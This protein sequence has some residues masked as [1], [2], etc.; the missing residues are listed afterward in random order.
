MKKKNIVKIASLAAIILL[1][2]VGA[3]FA[4]F[5]DSQSASNILSMGHVDISLTEEMKDP[6]DPDGPPVP[7]QDPTNLMPGDVISKIPKITVEKNSLA[8]YIRAVVTVTNPPQSDPQVTIAH[9]NVSDDWVIVPDKKAENIWYCYYVGGEDAG[10]V[11]PGQTLQ[12]FSEVELPGRWQ[13]EMNDTQVVVDIKA[14]AIQADH[15]TP[16]YERENGKIISC[17][18]LNTEGKEVE[19]EVYKK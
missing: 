5:T 7:Y 16:S 1:A 12:L 14:E 4:Y 6:S 18:W 9:I 19:A 15:F 11:S 8:C 10:I 13:N 3:T 17:S 2:G